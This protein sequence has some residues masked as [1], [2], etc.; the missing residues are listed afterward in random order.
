MEL[1][2]ETV[3]AGS[4]ERG[5]TNSYGAGV[6]RWTK[7]INIQTAREFHAQA[8]EIMTPGKKGP[9]MMDLSEATHVDACG[10]QLLV[11]LAVQCLTRGRVF[12]VAR[13]SYAIERDLQLAGVSY[14]LRQE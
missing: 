13:A 14:L 12:E 8:L 5:H 11:A 7:P 10:L 9:V 4:T 2:L 1:T 6:W 3:A